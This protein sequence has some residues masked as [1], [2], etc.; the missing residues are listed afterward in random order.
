MAGFVGEATLYA[1]ADAFASSPGS[2]MIDPEAA[3]PAPF[4]FVEQGWPWPPRVA[5]E[6]FISEGVFASARD[7]RPVA[8]LAGVVI[9]AQERLN[10]LTGMPF[11]HS[12]IRTA[13]FEVD[14]L[15]PPSLMEVPAPGQIVSAMAYMV[16]AFEGWTGEPST[17][18][19][20][21]RFVTRITGRR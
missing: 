10:S 4:H 7:A 1:D 6:S 12:R 17:T 18:G 16:G 11:T 14:L 19:V 13:G 3:G 9:E 8:R 21:S 2:L 15:A 5:A 20:A